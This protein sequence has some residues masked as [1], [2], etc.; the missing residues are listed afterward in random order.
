MQ[1]RRSGI[2]RGR[3]LWSWPA[4][5][6]SF[7]PTSPSSQAAEIQLQLGDVFFSEGRYL[8]ALDAYRN[9]L[10]V[11]P[12]DAV[13][14]AARRRHHVGAARR[15]VRTARVR[16]PKRCIAADPNNPQS[17]TLYADALWA[18][19]LFEEAETRYQRR[20]R[21]VA[22]SGARPSR[23][24]QG[25]RRAQ[26]ARRGDER[27]ADGAAAVAAR[28]RD[29]PHG[30]HDLRADAQVR[31]GGGRLHQLREP[32]A[33]QGSQREGRLVARRDPVP[34]L[35]RPAR[36]VRNGSRAPTISSTPSTSAW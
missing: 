19:G 9:A 24:G 32:A 27:S 7:A 22:R 20:A 10:K 29:P 31:R 2:R 13:R 16:K 1:Q 17:L 3:R 4:P 8:D 36:A 14:A 5:R 35:V 25:A 21:R 15:G 34:A 33:E 30:R 26:P 23:H 6:S 18:S 28:S 12:P 11:A